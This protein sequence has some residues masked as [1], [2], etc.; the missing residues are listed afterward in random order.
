MQA[1][2]E[3]FWKTVGEILERGLILKIDI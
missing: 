1:K 3:K 2:T